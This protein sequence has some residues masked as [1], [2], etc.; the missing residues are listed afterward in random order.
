MARGET[1]NRMEEQ[2]VRTNRLLTV[3]ALFIVFIAAIGP[4]RRHSLTGVT[5]P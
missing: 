3:P 5:S 1:I 4:T 2:R